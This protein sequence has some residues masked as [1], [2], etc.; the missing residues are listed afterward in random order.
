MKTIKQ[1]SL[2]KGFLYLVLLVILNT[3]IVFALPQVF[4]PKPAYQTK[5]EYGKSLPI[6][7]KNTLTPVKKPDRIRSIMVLKDEKIIYEYGPT[8]KIMFGASTR[9]SFLSL[10]YGIAIE[11]GLIDI[12]KTLA[13]LGIDENPSLTE[14][15]KT[16]TIRDLLMFRSGIYLPAEG[17]H[18][19]QITHRPLRD[20]H[21]PGT[22]FFS[23]NFDANALGTIFIQETGYSIGEFMEEFLAKPLGMQDFDSGNV[24]MGSPW[25]WPGSDSKHK[26]YNMYISTRDF[27][28]IGSLVA[29]EGQWNNVQIISKDWIKESTKPHSNLS[30]N[31]IDYSNSRYDAFG[32][33]WWIDTRTGTIWTD[34]YGGHFMLIDP[35]RNLIL[36]ERNFTGNSLLST[37]MWFINKNMDQSLPNLIKAHQQIVEDLDKKEN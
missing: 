25:F 24:I 26:M 18:D 36:V 21:K 31:H 13:E 1:I 14:Q 11:K 10:L 23:N 32:Y 27:A 33:T 29:N 19:N 15:E 35:V 12:N 5:L 37:G 34:G 28:R 2:K 20:S 4:N 7:I 9:K 6:H 16:A 3:L 17:E 22:Y 8:D 30:E